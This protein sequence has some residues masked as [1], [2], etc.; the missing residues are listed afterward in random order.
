MHRWTAAL[1]LILFLPIVG[2]AQTNESVR[3]PSLPDVLQLRDGWSLQSSCKVEQKG[4]L[5]STPKFAPTGWYAASVPTT[6]VGAL[7]KHKIYP[8]PMFGMNLRGFPGVTYPIGKNFSELELRQASPFMV[9]W[10]YRKSFTLPE[11][12]RG[13][14]ICLNFD[15]IN[16]RANIFLNGKQ[17]AGY[18]DGGGAW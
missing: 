13:K 18:D 9:P 11:S 16:Y 10:W 15:G 8:N 7:V 17:I 5:I 2:V 12:Y 6:V 1:L 3:T 14:A 4:E